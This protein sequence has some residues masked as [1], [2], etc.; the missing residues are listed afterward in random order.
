MKKPHQPH[1]TMETEERRTCRKCELTSKQRKHFT[2]SFAEEYWLGSNNAF[3]IQV[4]NKLN[5]IPRFMVRWKRILHGPYNLNNIGSA[6]I[7]SISSEWT[8]QF[9]I[10]L[11]FYISLSCLLGEVYLV[12]GKFLG[13]ESFFVWWIGSL[14]LKFNNRNFRNQNRICRVFIS[15]LLYRCSFN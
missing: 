1:N 5:F 2:G 14:I 7:M 15:K 12:S 10:F 4:D 11:F 8:T 13:F 9:R 3:H 6:T